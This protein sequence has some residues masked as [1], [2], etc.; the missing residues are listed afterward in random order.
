MAADSCAARAERWR[1]RRRLNLLSVLLVP[2]LLLLHAVP[3]AGRGRGNFTGATRGGQ[4][5]NCSAGEA[6]EVSFGHPRITF[7]RSAPSSFRFKPPGGHLRVTLTPDDAGM[8]PDARLSLRLANGTC[9]LQSFSQEMGGDLILV[10][11]DTSAVQNVAEYV[12][13]ILCENACAYHIAF[14]TGQ[15][16]EDEVALPVGEQAEGVAYRGV[17]LHYFIDCDDRCVQAAGADNTGQRLTVNL[18]PRDASTKNRL[19]LLVRFNEAPTTKLGEHLQTFGGWFSGEVASADAQ[20]GRYYVTVILRHGH[21]PL[22]FV[23]SARLP[24]AVQKLALAK[25][26]FGAISSTRMAFFRFFVSDP[27][28]DIEVYLTKIDGDPDLS[29][30]HSA[31]NV[32]PTPLAAQW[33]SQEVGD[34]E[35][36]IPPSDP[37]R[38]DHL[39][40]WFYVGV[41]GKEHSSFSILALAEQSNP[42]PGGDTVSI[43][44][45]E[46]WLGQPQALSA[47][48]GRAANFLFYSQLPTPRLFIRIE[49]IDGIR[50]DLC[51]ENCGP[52]AHECPFLS[53]Y[54]I[55][56]TADT[57]PAF[58]SSCSGASLFGNQSLGVMEASVESPCTGCWYAI[59][60]TSA[61]GRSK[62]RVTLGA[63]GHLQ[64]LV[65]GRPFRGHV[66]AGGADVSLVYQLS[67]EDARAHAKVN[68]TMRFLLT[69]L[70]GDPEF[71]VRKGSE[72]GPIVFNSS[73]GGGSGGIGVKDFELQALPNGEAAGDYYL[74]VWAATAHASFR[75]QLSW[76]AALQAPPEEGAVS[77]P[78]SDAAAGLPKNSSSGGSIL[79]LGL[80]WLLDGEIAQ[81]VLVDGRPDVYVFVPSNVT[82]RP[83]IEVSCSPLGGNAM[84]LL[85]G[86]V[87][88]ELTGRSAVE[89]LQRFRASPQAASTF[90][91]EASTPALRIRSS[92]PGYAR[93]G[94][95][96]IY[97]FLVARSDGL[98]ARFE[99]QI[100]AKA[101]GVVQE[102]SPNGL[103][104]AD[105]L[106]VGQYRRYR[107]VLPEASMHLA[108]YLRLLSGDSD[109]YLSRNASVSRRSFDLRSEALGS[110][111]IFVP[112]SAE[113]ARS[114][115]A[116]KGAGEC[117][118]Y[119]AV[120]GASKVSEFR[121]SA[122]VANAAPTPL[123]VAAAAA[124]ALAP[125]ERQAFVVDLDFPMQPA[126]LQVE[127]ESGR[128]DGLRVVVMP[129][130]T[131]RQPGSSLL[132]P[133]NTAESLAGE[134]NAE[135]FAGV[136]H[137]RLNE[138]MLAPLCK[139]A[140][141]GQASGKC[142]A[143]V[144]LTT[145]LTGCVGTARLVVEVPAAAPSDAG[146]AAGAAAAAAGNATNLQVL[147][148]GKPA[149]REIWS[150]SGAAAVPVALFKIP[151]G[152]RNDLLFS[153]SPLTDCEVTLEVQ[154]PG[155]LVAERLVFEAALGS[156]Q[157]DGRIPHSHAGFRAGLAT[158]YLRPAGGSGASSASAAAGSAAPVVCEVDLRGEGIES[159]QK[160]AG[161]EQQ[162]WEDLTSG[163]TLPMVLQFGVPLAGSTA[164]GPRTYV[165]TSR[166]AAGHPEER[167]WTTI[168]VTQVDGE[169]SA[170]VAFMPVDDTVA[171]KKSRLEE[172]VRKRGRCIGPENAATTG[173]VS[174]QLL[175][176]GLQE[177][178]GVAETCQLLLRVQSAR[179]GRSADFLVSAV[180]GRAQHHRRETLLFG[181]PA[182]G[183]VEDGVAAS[184]STPAGA[185]SP[186]AM[187]YQL[188]LSNPSAKLQIRLSCSA[189]YTSR[190][191]KVRLSADTRSELP[192]N[193]AERAYLPSS[194]PEPSGKTLAVDPSRRPGPGR[195]E[196][197]CVLLVYV[198]PEPG[199]KPVDF[200]LV[201]SV[202]QDY[203]LLLDGGGPSSVELQPS[204]PQY[205][206]FTSRRPS[207]LL[208]LVLD[209]PYD[210]SDPRGELVSLYAL[211]CWRAGARGSGGIAASEFLRDPR[212]RPSAEFHSFRGI[213]NPRG[214]L[215]AHVVN[216]DASPERSPGD[217]TGSPC[218]YRIAVESHRL[219]PAQ[220]SIRGFEGRHGVVLPL[221][222]PLQGLVRSTARSASYLLES[223]SNSFVVLSLEVCRGQLQLSA[224]DRGQTE[225]S[226]AFAGAA[227]RPSLSLQGGM[228]PTRVRA[229]ES[230]WLEVSSADGG[231]GSYIL[232]AEDPATRRW[233]S[234][235][236]GGDALEAV[237]VGKRQAEVRWKP[238]LLYGAGQPVEGY[239]TGTEYEVFYMV[240]DLAKAN[241]STP[242]GLYHEER[243]RV[244]RRLL[245]QSRL[246][247][248]IE[249]LKPATSYV[250]NVVA[251]S[252]RTGHS[253]AYRP[254]T[255]RTAAEKAP[256]E[257]SSPQGTSTSASLGFLTDAF[258]LIMAIAVAAG[259]VLAALPFCRG[260]RALKSLGG[261]RDLEL[262]SAKTSR[263]RP[264]RPLAFRSRSSYEPM[265]STCG[266]GDSFRGAAG[267]YA[268][269]SILGAGT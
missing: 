188:Y 128:L 132:V 119:I 5:G 217:E 81:G 235:A 122:L 129:A 23:L 206:V 87:L 2:L 61:Q 95:E 232:T 240:A 109:L 58:V 224:A 47:S 202:D 137:A 63:A 65:V 21:S 238:A 14:R 19:R 209:V 165:L 72:V 236:G 104:L 10:A 116:K 59:L 27:N 266:D 158:L 111:V 148:P 264:T 98:A 70:Y 62:F 187:V 194:A 193:F 243:R 248:R 171:D 179:P 34:D 219:A 260:D 84:C 86:I 156:H 13:H 160:A 66:D 151:N 268:P 1:K 141:L 173:V 35:I 120:L 134:V 135:N 237:G 22:P 150:R 163:R 89:R 133:H 79:D 146:A 143:L 124:V 140:I 82:G 178:C 242:C 125:G 74:R 11:N 233:L 251:R 244:A 46:L 227:W 245:V 177:H 169:V 216:S 110:D 180:A 49:V 186:K 6:T 88:K 211:G 36:V 269:P 230:R 45:T 191:Q 261:G 113:F 218:Y 90:R 228:P 215:V 255:M 91:S 41:H 26:M 201:A 170:E 204:R 130:Q 159:A 229:D 8:D 258:L 121:I 247:A 192:N 168:E 43:S 239:G 147:T 164:D 154:L 203:T 223:F 68:D 221:G 166:I 4:R 153:A 214:Q 77:R 198:E 220:V 184:G 172:A 252:L 76:T 48:P 200:E 37:K 241:V 38:K 3:S 30:S 263:R 12:L 33:H 57:R 114:H 20:R 161:G 231:L 175:C 181:I 190:C 105:T 9:I 108:I 249:G 127:L 145:G 40:G 210:A 17:P 93:P 152:T 55:N 265:D 195:C 267:S 144:V 222:S 254:L 157:V 28:T 102:L 83:D 53:P 52:D 162:P 71:Y 85:F 101:G 196:V 250:I 18:W 80:A 126:M 99:Y 257:A 183:R 131:A 123:G 189:S 94:V 155:A 106:R 207:P 225:A 262:A 182:A 205:F 67:A 73:A 42:E 25:P 226:D 213:P 60:V 199:A 208:T 92:D 139:R 115:C 256:D 78:P 118:Y 149:R 7:Q 174:R 32:R 117:V 107:V 259:L 51:A 197:P 142:A 69:P 15:A 100:E 138:S 136:W 112:P 176:P 234:P 246:S 29:M 97:A 54:S 103:P 167:R 24:E 56:V 39:T 185:L 75:L 44:W 253:I 212:R 64:P 16:L 96:G 31:V 50:P